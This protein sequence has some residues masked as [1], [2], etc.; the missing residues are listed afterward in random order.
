MTD[1]KMTLILRACLDFLLRRILSK[2]Y[3]GADLFNMKCCLATIYRHKS[4]R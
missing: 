4:S 2:I 1:K 3:T